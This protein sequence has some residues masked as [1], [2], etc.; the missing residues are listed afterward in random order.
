[1]W[2]EMLLGREALPE[3]NVLTTRA[4]IGAASTILISDQT[5]MRCSMVTAKSLCNG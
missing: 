3:A 5:S 2:S 4:D 1:M